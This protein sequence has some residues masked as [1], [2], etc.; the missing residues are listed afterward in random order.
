MCDKERIFV[1]LVF[2]YNCLAYFL[3]SIIYRDIKNVVTSHTVERCRCVS[4]KRCV[5]SE[6]ML[7]PVF[8]GVSNKKLFGLQTN[9]GNLLLVRP[10]FETK[11]GLSKLRI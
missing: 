11:F 9:L 7:V 2:V 6:K 1:V 3:S 8:G 5:L 10:N 4:P